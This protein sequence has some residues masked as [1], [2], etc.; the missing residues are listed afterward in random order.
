MVY[1]SP[2]HCN[3]LELIVLEDYNKAMTYIACTLLVRFVEAGESGGDD[4]V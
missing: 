2:C 1:I 4:G 3:V